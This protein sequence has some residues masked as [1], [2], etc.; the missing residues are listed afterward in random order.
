LSNTILVIEDANRPTATAGHYAQGTAANVVLGWGM[1]VAVQNQPSGFT[2]SD[3]F[4]AKDGGGVV[5]GTFG[6]PYGAPNRWADPDSASG[7]SG[8]PNTLS[9]GGAGVINNNKNA[10]LNQYPNT[11]NAGDYGFMSS[12]NPVNN[13][14]GTCYWGVNN[15]GPNDEPFSPHVGGAHCLMGDGTVRF[16]SENLSVLT[17][18]ELANRND[19][20]SV[21]DF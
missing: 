5:P 10:A 6:G 4:S 9:A 15:C 20:N 12:G 19:G 16:L 2:S 1:E 21:G 11:T 14:S 7:I 3:M 17:L 18:G 13:P 8:P